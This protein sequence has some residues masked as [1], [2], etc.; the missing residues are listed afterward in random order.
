MIQIPIV[1]CDPV[2]WPDRWIVARIIDIL[3]IPAPERST[4]LSSAYV[5][6]P[7][8]ANSI[9]ERLHVHDEQSPWRD[10]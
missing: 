5:L 8:I 2:R 7:S 3:Y 6:E 1:S 9:V 10:S 4:H